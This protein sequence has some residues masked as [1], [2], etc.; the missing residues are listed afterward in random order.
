LNGQAVSGIGQSGTGS[1]FLVTSGSGT[2][3]QNYLG[4]QTVSG[5]PTAEQ[6][7]LPGNVS[8]GRLTW[9]QRR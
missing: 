1:A 8:G 9:I 2:G 4:T 6:V 7:N 5:T 3:L